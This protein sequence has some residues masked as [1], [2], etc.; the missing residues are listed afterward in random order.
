MVDVSQ[1]H[2][3]IRKADSVWHFAQG[4][5]IFEGSVNVEAG[6]EAAETEQAAMYVDALFDCV[7]VRLGDTDGNPVSVPALN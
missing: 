3:N 5:L 2:L 1:D 4:S 6:E 7:R